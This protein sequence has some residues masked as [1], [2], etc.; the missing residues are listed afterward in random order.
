MS[1]MISKDLVWDVGLRN[2]PYFIFVVKDRS[3]EFG[4]K[5]TEHG[6]RFTIPA[7]GRRSFSHDWELSRKLKGSYEQERT[8]I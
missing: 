6:I 7:E 4:I 5:K 2:M 3:R 1:T 8:I